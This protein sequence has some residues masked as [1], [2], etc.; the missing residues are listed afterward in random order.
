MAKMATVGEVQA[1]KAAMRRHDSLVDLEV[2]GASAQALD[3]DT[4]LRRV[5]VE[6][7]EGTLLAEELDLVDM[8]VSSVVAST[9]VALRVL[10]G[11]GRTQSVEDSPRGDILR[12]D[13]DDGLPLTL[14]L[15]FLRRASC[16][17]SHPAPLLREDVKGR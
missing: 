15:P 6:G 14:Y 5:E 16:V 4:P 11:H 1:H 9:G 3:V 7:L 12:S 8:L 2:G 13:E 17:N 10:V